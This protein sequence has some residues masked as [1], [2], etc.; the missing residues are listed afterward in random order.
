MDERAHGSTASLLTYLALCLSSSESSAISFIIRQVLMSCSTNELK[1]R[2]V[3][4][5]PLGQKYR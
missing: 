5:E 4:W 1:L 3:S 2:G